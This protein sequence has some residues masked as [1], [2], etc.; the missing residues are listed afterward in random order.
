MSGGS[1]SC[2]MVNPIRFR[3]L[4]PMLLCAAAI[5]SCSREEESHE[6]IIRHDLLAILQEMEANCPEITRY[7]YTKRHAYRVECSN[8][9]HFTVAVDAEGRIQVLTPD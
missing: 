7:E 1:G 2:R 3:R 5:L 4:L 8:Q 9:E 6:E